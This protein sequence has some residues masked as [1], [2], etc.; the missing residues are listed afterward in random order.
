MSLTNI[1]NSL[2]ETKR[3]SYNLLQYF[4]KQIPV[5]RF[6]KL[7]NEFLTVEKTIKNE[8]PA[9]INNVE[10]TDFEQ[11]KINEKYYRETVARVL[12]KALD[13]YIDQIHQS[14]SQE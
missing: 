6:D 4:C 7:L 11:Y 5:E 13:F 12:I 14:F 9:M 1:L 2:N 3:G 8:F 10:Q